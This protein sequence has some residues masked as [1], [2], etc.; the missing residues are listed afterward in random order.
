M[1]MGITWLCPKIWSL[2]FSKQTRRKKY[3]LWK[4][5]WN[6]HMPQVTSHVTLN[7]WHIKKQNVR[8]RLFWFWCYYPHT[9]IYSNQIKRVYNK[10]QYVRKKINFM[11]HDC[12]KKLNR[13]I[14]D[15]YK[16]KTNQKWKLYKY[17]DLLETQ[18]IC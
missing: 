7:M 18:Q 15:G 9:L 10:K 14:I 17:I 8:F 1:T 4:F 11:I 12:F 5:F 3:K 2:F 6:A 16:R 13:C